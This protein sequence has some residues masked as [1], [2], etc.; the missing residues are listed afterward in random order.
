MIA[1]LESQHQAT[2]PGVRTGL[3]AETS[4]AVRRWLDDH[5]EDAAAWI[6]SHY[7]PYVRKII[8]GWLPQWWMSED[9]AQDVFAKAFSALGRYEHSRAFSSWLAAI[10]RNTCAKALKLAR[11]QQE[12]VAEEGLE[13]REDES[14]F[15]ML[16]PSADAAIL[17]RERSR[18]IR[19]L[20]LRLRAA[21]RRVVILYR[22]ERQS[23]EA[24]AERL[25]LTAG[26]VRIRAHRAE[27]RLRE[28]WRMLERG[29]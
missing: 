29:A 22:I 18:M 3:Q 14:S 28:E 5:D 25:H 20:L 4:E 7:R 13:A 9:V 24:V 17:G 19:E 10:A 12:W 2:I 15:A 8:E 1:I 26:N 16:A 11:R 23:A 6:V 21:D 27:R